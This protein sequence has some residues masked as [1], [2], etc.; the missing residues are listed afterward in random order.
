MTA[1]RRK[2]LRDRADFKD[3][4]AVYRARVSRS[5]IPVGNDSLPMGFDH[6]YDNS[7][8]LAIFVDAF[9]K[10]VS[11]LGIRQ[12]CSGGLRVRILQENGEHKG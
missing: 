12:A 3:R 10:D 2:D 7:N 8:G 11:N 4:V 1:A 6:P 9:G 5:P